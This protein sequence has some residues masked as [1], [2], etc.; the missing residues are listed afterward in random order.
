VEENKE[1]KVSEENLK[2]EV[3]LMIKARDSFKQ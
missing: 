2:K 3:E 1:I